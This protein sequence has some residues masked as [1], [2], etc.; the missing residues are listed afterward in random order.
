MF[1]IYIY[2]YIYIILRIRRHRNSAIGL[3]S[4]GALAKVW[5]DKQIQNY[6]FDELTSG[7][8]SVVESISKVSSNGCCPTEANNVR[9]NITLSN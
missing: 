7:R 4:I 9:I 5:V 1:Y 3:V 8:G 6:L 2:I